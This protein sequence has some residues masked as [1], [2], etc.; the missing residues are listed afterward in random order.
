M[1]INYVEQHCG[2]MCAGYLLRRRQGKKNKKRGHKNE[3]E[4]Q[5][6]DE[7]EQKGEELQKRFEKEREDRRT[8]LSRQKTLFTGTLF[9]AFI[10]NL[11]M[12]IVY[13]SVKYLRGTHLLRE[14]SVYA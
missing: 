6:Q 9:A 13:Y 8:R 11:H 4:Q 10:K 7:Q 1:R 2:R 12:E 14:C 5:E 3:E